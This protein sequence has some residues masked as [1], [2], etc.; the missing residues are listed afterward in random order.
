MMTEAQQEVLKILKRAEVPL[1]QDEVMACVLLE[2]QINMHQ[3]MLDNVL[4]GYLEAVFNGDPETE[5]NNLDKF[6]FK[7]TQKGKE[8]VEVPRKK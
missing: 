8:Y 4:K 2:E 3:S 7:I 1:T 5:Y 6:S